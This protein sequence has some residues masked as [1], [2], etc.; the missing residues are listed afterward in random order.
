MLERG[1]VVAGRFRVIDALGA[2]AIGVVYS[3][4]R[5]GED[6]PELA[7]KV[8]EEPDAARAEALLA[9]ARR[10]IAVTHPRIV[11]TL[12]CGIDGPTVWIAMERVSGRS[13]AEMLEDGP[14]A[15]ADMVRVVVA[16]CSALDAAH[17]VG[18]LHSDLNPRNVI[19]GAQGVK[20]T[21]FTLA[22]ARGEPTRYDSPET[23]HGYPV[24]ERSDLYSLGVLAIELVTGS[25]YHEAED[26]P[27]FV[28]ADVPP[29]VR[30]VL[31]RL[32]HKDRGARFRN[33]AAVAQAL[34]A[35]L[36]GQPAPR[37]RRTARR[38]VV[39][40]ALV[41]A[42]AVLGA[43]VLIRGRGGADEG[44]VVVNGVPVKPDVLADY[45]RRVRHHVPE[46]RYWY[47]PLTGA[48]GREGAPAAGVTVPGLP[49]GRPDHTARPAATLPDR[50]LGA[51]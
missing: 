35:A 42:A 38:R 31:I 49:L 44:K 34:E 39:G 9:A 48:W 41:A 37:A 13:L 22:G 50:P 18:I 32:L 16:V 45:E 8:I 36:A 29:M 2:G 26:A 11:R 19:V 43:V 30:A 14:L 25:A 1:S 23:S 5:V 10:T 20:V 33:A 6:G 4:A 47:E 40:V 51:P 7:L 17:A 28:P 15:V 21:N 12:D 27:L 3:V 46:G 24:D